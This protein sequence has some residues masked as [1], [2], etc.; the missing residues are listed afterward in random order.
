MNKLTLNPDKPL[1]AVCWPQAHR[2]IYTEDDIKNAENHNIW[3]LSQDP[4]ECGWE[5]D[6]GC[7][8]YGLTKANAELIIAR[9]NAGLPDTKESKK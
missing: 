7:A 9:W 1:Y 6:A 5:T 3:T 8:D 2:E 4:N